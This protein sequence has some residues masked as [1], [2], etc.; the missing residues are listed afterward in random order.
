MRRIQL[1]NISS[2]MVLAKTIFDENDKVLLYAGVEIKSEY[3]SRLIDSGISE[4]YVD[5]D[6]SREVQPKEVLCEETRREAKNLAKTLM[7]SHAFIHSADIMHVKETV[8]K[9][10]EQLFLNDDI[11]IN[12]Y[13]IKTV[14]DYT[15]SHC[16][17]VCIYSL[18][19]G[20]SL[21][22][23]KQRLKDLGVGAILHDIGKLTIS[24]YILKK[25]EQ[26][27]DTEY[28]E[29]KKHARVG[30][31]IL[32]KNKSVSILS[33][34]IALSHH[35]R[36]DGTGYPAKLSGNDIHECARIVAIADVYDALTSDRVYRKKLRPHEV[37]EYITTIG[38]RHF[39]PILVKNF[40]RYIALY[41]L[42]SGVIL[43][44]RERA[45]VVRINR[46]LPTRP[47]VKVM[48]DSCGN[49]LNDFYLIDISN[50]NG[51]SIIGACEI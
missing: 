19:I 24:E 9:I 33:S 44:T 23:S 11:I 28:E 45:I 43:N 5:D 20:I 16:V 8:N 15:F 3:I 40:V 39:D 51:I 4:V 35:E 12:L 25:P 10:I 46:Q 47:V 13:E 41:P 37:V 42:G 31:E 26:L 29:I 30:F 7:E 49:K 18:I 38:A 48:I 27:N 21:G 50:I 32:S 6:V 14:D 36:F 17:N 34:Y 2:G 22:Y 1:S